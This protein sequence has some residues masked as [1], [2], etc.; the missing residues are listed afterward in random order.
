MFIGMF[1]PAKAIGLA[2][3]L[4]KKRKWEE[5]FVSHQQSGKSGRDF[6]VAPGFWRGWDQ[7]PLTFVK[8]FRTD[9]GAAYKTF[10]Y[11]SQ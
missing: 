3:K 4:E 8:M 6:R 10:L 9:F 11:N 5:R 7:V 2:K 1:V